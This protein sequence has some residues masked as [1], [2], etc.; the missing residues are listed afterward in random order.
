MVTY[1]SYYL[2]ILHTYLFIYNTR[3]EIRVLFKYKTHIVFLIWG[4]EKK[5][6]NWNLLFKIKIQIMYTSTD[7]IYKISIKYILPIYWRVYN[8]VNVAQGLY[9]KFTVL[10]YFIFLRISI[11]HLS[12]LYLT[13]NRTFIEWQYSKK[14]SYFLLIYPIILLFLIIFIVFSF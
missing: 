12:I 4:L 2:S 1:L 11:V 5:K 13:A 8:C 10:F 3:N 9:I 14:F 6:K 7:S